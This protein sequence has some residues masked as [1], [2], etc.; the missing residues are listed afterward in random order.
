MKPSVRQLLIAWAR[1]K[2]AEPVQPWPDP[3][4]DEPP[5]HLEQ[6]LPPI[7]NWEDGQR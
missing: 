2:L 5:C 4:A 6:S 3:F 1:A 7:D